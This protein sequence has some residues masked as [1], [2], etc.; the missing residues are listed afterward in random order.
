VVW[1]VSEKALGMSVESGLQDDLAMRQDVS[2]TTVVNHGGRHQAQPGM[3][4]LMVVPLKEGRA[5]AACILD[6]AE[7]IRK[8]RPVFKSRN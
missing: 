1:A 5:E 2:G 4:V 6:G 7:A 8:A 3:M